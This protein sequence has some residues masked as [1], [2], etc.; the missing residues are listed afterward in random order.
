MIFELETSRLRIRDLLAEDLESM[1]AVWVDPQVARFMDNFGPRTPAQT[2]EWLS[3]AI[4]AR[5]ADPSGFGCSIIE[6]TTGAVI[7][8]IGFGR[9]NRDVAPIDVAYVIASDHRGKGYAS[10]ALRRVISFIL[11]ELGVSAVW[12]EC[13]VDN[14]AS[15]RVMVTAGLSEIGLVEGQRR[16]IIEKEA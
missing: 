9:S 12:G 11:D 10:E 8:W 2:A 6:R 16:F 15:A 14:A 7:G 5:H 1:V 3:A 4:A 13:H